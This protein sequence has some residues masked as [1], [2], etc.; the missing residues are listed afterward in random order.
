[1]EASYSGF[2]MHNHLKVTFDLYAFHEWNAESTI[3]Q[4][5]IGST[6]RELRNIPSPPNQIFLCSG[7]PVYFIQITEIFSNQEYEAQIKL[8]VVNPTAQQFWGIRNFALSHDQVC[9]STC[10]SCVHEQ[11][12]SSCTQCM[13]DF[14]PGNKTDLTLNTFFCLFSCEPKDHKHIDGQ[15]Q[16]VCEDGYYKDGYNCRYCDF[17]CETCSGPAASNCLSCNEQKLFA[18]NEDSSQCECASG[19]YQYQFQCFECPLKCTSCI[20]NHHCTNCKENYFIKQADRLCHRCDIQCRT[21][22][23]RS[24][25]CTSCYQEYYRRLYKSSCIC[26][27]LY[28]SEF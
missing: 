14:V 9:D 7:I 13:M 2:P 19:Y 25:Q 22:D 17:T 12:P 11:D 28:K 1:M 24:G 27:F 18:F 6:S 26:P 23:Y 8:S 5:A 15:N 3:L 4:L 20:S 10:F 21:C 16:C